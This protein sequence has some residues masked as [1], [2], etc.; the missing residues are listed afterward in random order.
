MARLIWLTGAS[1]SGK[2]SLLDALRQT[3]PPR[4][5][6]AHRYITRPAQAGGEN[7]V[8][9]SEAEFTHRRE[10]GLFALHWQAHQYQYGVGIEIDLWLSAGLDVVVNGSRSHHPQAQQRYGDRLLPVCL[11]VSPE[12]LAQRL[13]QRGREDDAQIALRL[14][15]AA[16]MTVPPAYRRLNNDGPLAQT[17]QAFHTLLAAEKRE[18]EKWT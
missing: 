12:V 10:C 9:L 6:V 5:L 17:L 15:R 13:R 1:G 7:H 18:T 11:Q 4:L 3:N 8:A 16:A 14:Q 2:D